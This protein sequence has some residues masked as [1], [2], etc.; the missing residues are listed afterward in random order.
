MGI[1]NKMKIMC[2]SC[3]NDYLEH[4]HNENLYGTIFSV[5]DCPDC[6]EQLYI[7]KDNEYDTYILR[8]SHERSDD[9]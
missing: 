1:D 9:E 6:G 8:D 3:R 4:D 5:Y 7:L 2:P